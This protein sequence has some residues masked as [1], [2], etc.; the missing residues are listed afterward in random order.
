MSCR[1]MALSGAGKRPA[2]VGRPGC[3]ERSELVQAVERS[4]FVRFRQRRIVE[5]GVAE[6][7][8]RTP[9]AN[10]RLPDMDDLGGTLADDVNAEQLERLS[11]EKQLQH[12]IL[13]A[14]HQALR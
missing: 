5:D 11:L 10:H 7:L 1:E 9:K 13:I 8:D 4:D 14:N 6:I 3:L 2:V 12:P